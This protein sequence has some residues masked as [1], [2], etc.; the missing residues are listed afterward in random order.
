[1]VPIYQPVTANVV[2]DKIMDLK[3]IVFIRQHIRICIGN[4]IINKGRISK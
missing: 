1:M 4:K 3:V 2:T